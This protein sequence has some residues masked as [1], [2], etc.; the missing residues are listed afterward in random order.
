MGAM[1]DEN[2]RDRQAVPERKHRYRQKA[3]GGRAHLRRAYG[4][5]LRR[6][7]LEAAQLLREEGIVRFA[8][9]EPED[10]AAL[11]EGGFS[12]E[13]ILMLRSTTDREEV[14]R[15]IDLNVVCTIGSY[16]SGLALNG[17]AE[18]RSTIAEAHVRWIPNGIRRFLVTATAKSISL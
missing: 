12:D 13:E 5:R 8:V 9:A 15:L 3:G 17:I 18:S 7:T 16:E 4:K 2:P 10:A 1:A 11:R 14:E 6:G